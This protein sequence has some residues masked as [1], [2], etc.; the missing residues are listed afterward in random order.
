MRI[1]EG[2]RSAALPL[3]DNITF[4]YATYNILNIVFAIC[5]H[6]KQTTAGDF[7][8]ARYVLGMLYI[9]WFF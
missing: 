7:G 5:I 4:I 3:V 9:I 6:G 2:T 1:F 8:Y